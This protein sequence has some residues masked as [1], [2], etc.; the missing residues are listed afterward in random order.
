MEADELP[1]LAYILGKEPD[2]ETGGFPLDPPR[3]L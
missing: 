1:K 2:D 3:L